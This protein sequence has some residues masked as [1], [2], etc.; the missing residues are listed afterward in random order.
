VGTG[1][2]ADVQ[3]ERAAIA[4]H[5]L[6]NE[7]FLLGYREDIP[8]ILS[9]MDLLIHCSYANEGVP[10]AVLQAMSMERPVVA[11]RVG[12]V[13]EAVRDGSSGY[14]VPPRDVQSLAD[15]TIELLRDDLKRKAFGQAG[16]RVVKERYSLETMLDRVEQLYQTLLPH[17]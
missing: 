14:L 5:G 11:T 6:Q 15:G 9:A 7:V 3:R 16:R 12:A 4:K 10:Q 1:F 2:P 17:N 13:S 8:E